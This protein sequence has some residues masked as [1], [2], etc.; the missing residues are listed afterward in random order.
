MPHSTPLLRMH[1]EEVHRSLGRIEGTLE[2]H[3]ERLDRIEDKVDSN[4]DKIR[5]KDFL[6]Y[7][8]GLIVLGLAVLGKMSWSDAVQHL[9]R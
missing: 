1:S 5:A 3:G 8:P 6:S 9:T 2:A 4:R 7:L